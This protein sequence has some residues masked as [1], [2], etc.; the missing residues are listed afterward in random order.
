MVDLW[1]APWV[2]NSG[3]CDVKPDFPENPGEKNLLELCLS[4][5]HYG[6]QWYTQG[7]RRDHSHAILGPRVS[8]WRIYHPGIGAFLLKNNFFWGN[9]F[10]V[11]RPPIDQ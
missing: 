10:F 2:S 11:P 4:G 1:P 8:T 6:G 7:M 3:V 5:V 9:I